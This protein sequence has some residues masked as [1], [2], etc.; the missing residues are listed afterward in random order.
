[1]LA[2]L[3]RNYSRSCT[4]ALPQPGVL[5]MVSSEVSPV[6]VSPMVHQSEVPPVVSSMVHESVSAEVTAALVT[7]AVA[8]VRSVEVLQWMRFAPRRPSIIIAF[9]F[10]HQIPCSF[11]LTNCVLQ[12]EFLWNHNKIQLYFSRQYAFL[13]WIDARLCVCWIYIREFTYFVLYKKISHVG[14]A[15]W[16]IK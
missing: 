7:H 15:I 4:A 10:G 8:A 12:W 5:F 6:M 14:E 13:H 16:S 11:L 9:R 2:G 1:M 3:V